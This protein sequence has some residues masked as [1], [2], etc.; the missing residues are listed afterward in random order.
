[1]PPISTKG[2]RLTGIILSWLWAAVVSIGSVLAF[3]LTYLQP[4]LKMI[5]QVKF[6]GIDVTISTLERE[7]R[8]PTTYRILELVVE[9]REQVAC[10]FMVWV[11]W[12]RVHGNAQ[13]NDGGKTYKLDVELPEHLVK[14]EKAQVA[15]KKPWPLYH[16]TLKT[17]R[18]HPIMSPPQAF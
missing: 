16:L 13:T 4:R 18:L 6:L 15:M 9:L 7:D 2:K 14:S 17:V 10:E 8:E 5:R 1:M 12:K 11:D 3:Y